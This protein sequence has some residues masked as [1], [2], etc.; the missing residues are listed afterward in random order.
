MNCAKNIQE[1]GRHTHCACTCAFYVL[2]CCLLSSCSCVLPTLSAFSPPK[3]YLS[4]VQTSSM[5]QSSSC[6]WQSDGKNQLCTYCMHLCAY[7]LR[8]NIWVFLWLSDATRCR[9]W[10]PPNCGAMFTKSQRIVMCIV[11]LSLVIFIFILLLL[12]R[13]CIAM[14]SWFNGSHSTCIISF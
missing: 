12:F 1:H 3:L 14:H 5:P 13:C 6:V 8:F 9:C 4:F 2:V 10:I 11:F 7:S